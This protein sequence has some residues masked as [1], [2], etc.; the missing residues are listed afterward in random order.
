VKRL[1]ALA[2]AAVVL[3]ACGTISASTAARDWAN[4]AHFRSNSV[5]LLADVHHAATTLHKPSSTVAD[6]HT[7]CA[8][9]L[10]DTQ[11]ANA[12]LPTPD[13]QTTRLLGAAYT[14]LGAGANRCYKATT[15]R[16]RQAALASLRQGLSSLS[17]G[18]ARLQ[19]LT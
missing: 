2:V 9:L 15:D 18:T 4:Q 10:V 6:L 14:S 3:S 12:S 16:Q 17:E 7:V 1:V 8:V 19:S 5:T 13:R 11:A